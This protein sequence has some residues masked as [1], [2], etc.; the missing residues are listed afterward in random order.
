[1]GQ[2]HI[3]SALM[4]PTLVKRLVDGL[5]IPVLT[6]EEHDAWVDL[7]P[8]TP[9]RTAIYAMAA[10]IHALARIALDLS[11]MGPGADLPRAARL[12]DKMRAVLGEGHG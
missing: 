7:N 8:V 11:C 12:L 6:R 10:E 5:P 4:G 2:E 9:S 3:E 1:M